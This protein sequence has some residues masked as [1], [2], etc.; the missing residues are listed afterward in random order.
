MY[1]WILYLD[2]EFCYKLFWTLSQSITRTFLL[3]SELLCYDCSR[4]L[5]GLYLHADLLDKDTNTKVLNSI[6]GLTALHCFFLFQS[7]QLH[8]N[9]VLRVRWVEGVPT[10]RPL[11][12]TLADVYRV[13]SSGP[14]WDTHSTQAVTGTDEC[15]YANT[16]PLRHH[17]DT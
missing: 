4:V 11:L 8:Q 2:C 15:I 5:K 10:S 6:E 1:S 3:S 14:T 13:M 9:L 17:V 12:Q 7:Y 16:S